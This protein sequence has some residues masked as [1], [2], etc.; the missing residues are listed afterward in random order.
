MNKTTEDGQR[1]LSSS[2]R[3][4]YIIALDISFLFLCSHSDIF[5]FP[6][7]S[8]FSATYSS[9]LGHRICTLC[10]HTVGGAIRTRAH[11]CGIA[12]LHLFLQLGQ[13]YI[14]FARDSPPCFGPTLRSLLRYREGGSSSTLVKSWGAKMK[15]KIFV[16]A[17]LGCLLRGALLFAAAAPAMRTG[18][19]W[20]GMMGT[21]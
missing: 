19:N 1:T 9:P 12:F 20:T 16:R 3:F 11:A 17:S 13:G 18:H 6:L 5:S 2:I 10:I 7:S 4:E 8:S 21:K 15:R 14:F